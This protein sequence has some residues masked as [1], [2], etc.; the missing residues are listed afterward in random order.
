VR[1][2]HFIFGFLVD[3]FE[4]A[5]GAFPPAPCAGSC[6]KPAERSRS[7]LKTPPTSAPERVAHHLPNR[8]RSQDIT[9]LTVIGL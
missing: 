7:W 5:Q 4:P 1:C 3:G 9:G 6:P 2:V 8:S